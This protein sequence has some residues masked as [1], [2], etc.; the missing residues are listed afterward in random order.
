MTIYF[1][2]SG[3]PGEL[4]GS[5]L[6]SLKTPVTAQ[7][8]ATYDNGAAVTMTSATITLH[9]KNLDTGGLVDFGGVFTGGVAL[10]TWQQNSGAVGRVASYSAQL[11]AKF[12]SGVVLVSHPFLYS[13]TV[14]H[15]ASTQRVEKTIVNGEP[16][17]TVVPLTATEQAAAVN[18]HADAVDA[19]FSPASAKAILATGIDPTLEDDP[20]AVAYLYPAWRVGVA[21]KVGDFIQYNALM[22]T[23]IQA[24]TS[25]VDWSPPIVPALF[26][27]VLA[28]GDVQWAYPVAYKIGD[29]VVYLGLNYRCIQAHT[30][31]AGWTPAAVPSLWTRI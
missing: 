16:V 5:L 14:A 25:Q 13:V 8:P 17:Y 2:V 20:D 29:E 31:Q 7:I 15:D 21:Y 24:H 19:S 12:S 6:A 18:A 3:V 27:R 1:P 4:R 23:V 28:P 22:W 10:V 30:S 11:T 26:N 9:G